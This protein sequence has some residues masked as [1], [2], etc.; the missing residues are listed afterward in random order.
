MG[1]EETQYLLK[2]REVT[3]RRLKEQRL[4][5]ATMGARTPADISVEIQ[6]AELEIARI[7]Q[8]L[9]LAHVS[10]EVAAATPDAE[11]GIVRLQI[12]Q[13]G[14][15]LS[16]AIEWT[17]KEFSREREET[18]D[19]LQWQSEQITDA[20]KEA[21]ATR[22]EARETREELRDTLASMR[23]DT[24]MW[25]TEQDYKRATGARE[26]RVVE[27]ILAVAVIIAI[28]LALR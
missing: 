21:R 14:E 2:L 13:V 11:I 17:Q 23:E 8:Q 5:K 6:T 28:Y 7:D 20:K 18:R 24:R 27:F 9:L 25:R 4:Q 1:D 16:A 12:K 3:Q 10:P 26:R 15:R 19:T 22:T